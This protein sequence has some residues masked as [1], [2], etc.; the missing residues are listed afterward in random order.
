MVDV[1]YV[2]RVTIILIRCVLTYLLP[3][4]SDDVVRFLASSFDK[5]CVAACK[6]GGGGR[7]CAIIYYTI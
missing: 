5:I 1:I 4:D 6:F 7:D 3:D 2:S